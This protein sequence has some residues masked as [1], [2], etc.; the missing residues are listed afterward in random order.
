MD[1]K[2]QKILW[3]LLM[4]FMPLSLF[5]QNKISGVLVDASNNEPL[6]GVAIYLEKDKGVGT[7]TDFDGV[8]ELPLSDGKYNLVF[9]YLGFIDQKRTVNVTGDVDL[10]Q[11]KMESS[12]VGLS[13]VSVVASFAT[14]RKTPVAIS[15]IPAA[16]IQEKLGNQEFPEVLKSTPS[17]Y[18]TKGAGGFGDSRV[19]IR[20][21]NTSNIGVLINGVPVNDMENGKVY[22]SNWAGLN[23]VTSV[24]QVQ[25]GLGASKLAISSVGG[26][27]NI[28][29]KSADAEQGGSFYAGMGN[30]G[31]MKT[32]FNVST[33]LME[34]G[35]ALTLMGGAVKGDG[36][37][38]GTSFEGYN[39]FANITK[40]INENHR[41]SFQIF[42][43]PQTHGQRGNKHLISTLE[44]KN[45]NLPFS[46]TS[47]AKY[48]S[49]YGIR[50][51]EEYGGGYGYNFYHKPQASINHYWNINSTTVL[52]T[53]VYAS[54]STG[55]GRRLRGDLA[56]EVEYDR[57]NF[58]FTSMDWRTGDGLIDWDKMIDH[59]NEINGKSDFIIA[60]SINSHQWYG[61]LSSLNTTVDNV[62][63]TFGLDSRYYLGEHY[64]QIDDLLGGQFFLDDKD[65][66]R[67][68][69]TPLRKGDIYSFN[70]DM[71]VL[72]NGLFAQAEFVLDQW[73]AFVSGASSY[74]NVRRIDYIQYEPGNQISDWANFLDWSIK[75]GANYNISDKHN[76]YANGGYFIR[77]P[78]IKFVFDG[79]TNDI[80]EDAPYEKVLTFEGGYGFK[81]RNLNLKLGVYHTEWKDQG[82][83]R[84]FQGQSFSLLGLNSLH[85]GVE[86]E[87][88]YKPTKNLT[89]TAMASVGDWKYTD[90]VRFQEF[91]DQGEFVGEFNAYVKDVSVGNSAQTTAAL[92]L[93]YRFFNGF[94]IG[95]DGNYFGRNFADFDPANRTTPETSGVDAWQIPDAY[96]MDLNAGYNFAIGN[97]MTRISGRINNLF[98]TVYITDADDGFT[99]QSSPVYYGFG[100]TYSLGLKVNF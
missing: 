48:N 27:M 53:S 1:F 70:N 78:F 90:D 26:T 7:I 35:W 73:S 17:V 84:S 32:N 57:N 92:G 4:V 97:V 77:S 55:G 13:E 65:V 52:S 94:N 87:G 3:V 62:N 81:T 45:E 25:R 24:M 93:N 50:N 79:Y 80:I 39:Y 63:L 20:G 91:D 67:S 83:S 68:D 30:D 9:N 64:E 5:A 86:F 100:R 46:N 44:D 31:Y 98:D 49:E 11:I 51:G 72:R 88:S 8:F 85:R 2:G 61:L 47:G 6:I 22:F 10:G 28:L 89:I 14:D 41:L 37:I 15:N 18:A 19:N 43:A 12:S 34:N 38:N 99:W 54:V 36:Y 60:N 76:V 74:Q 69:N 95:L 23:D 29:T 58:K 82:L 40:V 16:V 75:A 96:L 71:Q 33:G 66:N 59:N 42:G 56:S 21:F